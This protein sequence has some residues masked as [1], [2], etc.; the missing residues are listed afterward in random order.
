MLARRIAKNQI[1][2]D[3]DV[4]W[5]SVTTDRI[6]Q[7]TVTDLDRLVGLTPRHSLDAGK[8]IRSHDLRRPIIVPKG[9]LVTAILQLRHMTLTVRAKALDN[10]ASGDTIRV[11]NTK[12]RRTFEGVVTGPDMVAIKPLHRLAKN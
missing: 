1:I 11:M 3:S 5:I 4:E 8:P 6:Q 10:G 2:A 12:S 9:S 7:G